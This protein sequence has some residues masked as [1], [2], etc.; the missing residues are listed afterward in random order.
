MHLWGDFISKVGF[1][2]ALVMFLC[3]VAWS[4]IPD[5]KRWW[6]EN[7]RQAKALADSVPNIEHCLQRMADGGESQ[8]G[9]L[10]EMNRKLDLLLERH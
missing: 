10:R 6:R 7:A 4:I 2:I 3:F 5:I 1:P 9:L 8:T